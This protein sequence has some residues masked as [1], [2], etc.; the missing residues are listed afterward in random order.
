MAT[1]RSALMPF[2]G[3]MTCPPRRSRSYMGSAADT[4]PAT[5]RQSRPRIRGFTFMTS[6][7]PR[8][9]PS[10]RPLAAQVL[11]HVQCAPHLITRHLPREGVGDGVAALLAQAAAGAHA[12]PVDRARDVAGDEVAAMGAVDVVA[13]L[14]QVERVVGGARRVLD[15]HVPLAA[16][17]RGRGRGGKSLG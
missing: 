15:P 12:V 13:A 11:A 17:V 5:A 3:S 2:L 4:E 9:A 14:A 16:Q 10:R 7:P 1:S 8:G 6:T